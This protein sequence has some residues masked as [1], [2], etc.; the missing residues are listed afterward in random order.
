MAELGFEVETSKAS[1]GLL[2]FHSR[3]YHS[4]GFKAYEVELLDGELRLRRS[5]EGTGFTHM[6]DHEVPPE[7]AL[8]GDMLL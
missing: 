1:H 3:E 7:P 8:F 5:L 4:I 2:V 6:S